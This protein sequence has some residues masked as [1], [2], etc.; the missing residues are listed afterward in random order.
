MREWP[1]TGL[2]GTR[3]HH[4]EKVLLLACRRWFE[5]TY[6]VVPG[7]LWLCWLHCGRNSRS[8]PLVLPSGSIICLQERARLAG[9]MEITV[10]N[11]VQSA[12]LKR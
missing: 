7:A 12:E 6:V 5:R 8:R 4:Q 1:H 9:Q 2:G 3:A 11:G 10:K